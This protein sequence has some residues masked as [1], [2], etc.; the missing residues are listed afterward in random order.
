MP[1]QVL[2]SSTVLVNRESTVASCLHNYILGHSYDLRATMQ[3]LKKNVKA[4]KV[5][6][7]DFILFVKWCGT[8]ENTDLV[9]YA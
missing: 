7:F 8:S 5:F 4:I 9:F 2:A 1:I 6:R 3:P